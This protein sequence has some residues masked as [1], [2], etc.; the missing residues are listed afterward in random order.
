VGSDSL[1]T[2]H[3]FELS[4]LS[5]PAV[6]YYLVVSTD[7]GGNTATSSQSFFSTNL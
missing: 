2:E 3:E 5:A 4:D 1:S 6:Y 7:A